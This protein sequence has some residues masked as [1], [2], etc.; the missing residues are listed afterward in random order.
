M[1]VPSD[2]TAYKTARYVLIGVLLL[3]GGWM[4]QRFLPALSWAVVLAVATASLYDR[5]LRY[6]KGPHRALWAATTFTAI[7][8]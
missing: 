3:L 5:W 4:L 8:A 1:P 2:S 6:F 7:F